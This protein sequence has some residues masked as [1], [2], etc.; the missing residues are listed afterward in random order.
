MSKLF[1]SVGERV[2]VSLSLDVGDGLVVCAQVAEALREALQQFEDSQARG[3]G[4]EGGGNTLSNNAWGVRQVVGDENRGE[5]SEEKVR[6]L[7]EELA[8]ARVAAQAAEF[9]AAEAQQVASDV[10]LQVQSLRY[11]VPSLPLN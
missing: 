4:G 11:F 6:K 7:E 9:R 10:Q 2:L 3:G 5:V 1:A 8:T